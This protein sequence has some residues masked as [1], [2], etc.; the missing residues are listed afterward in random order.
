MERADNELKI[1][2]ARKEDLNSVLCLFGQLNL[3]HGKKLLDSSKARFEK[4]ITDYF[5]KSFSLESNIFIVA[6][7]KNKVVGFA[8]IHPKI[9]VDD[10]TGESK[11]FI[12]I[13]NICV[14]EMYRRKCIAKK[15]L[16][17]IEVV[18]K[19]NKCDYMELT[20]YE[21][22]GAAKVYEDTG[23]RTVRKD[24]IKKINYEEE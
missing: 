24:M 9:L 7:D 14:D 5:I 6:Q 3:S 2:H 13:A 23:F 19:K 15:L 21:T 10:I 1:R 17:F 12:E 22:S 4:K 20:V 16:A 11:K 8:D 18:A